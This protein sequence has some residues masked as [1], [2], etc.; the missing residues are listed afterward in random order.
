MTALGFDGSSWNDSVDRATSK[1]AEI[2][3]ILKTNLSLPHGTTMI[4]SRK[5]FGSQIRWRLTAPL[6]LSRPHSG[7]RG[8]ES[9]R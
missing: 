5:Y 4:R 7:Y 1:N 8:N 6:I 3:Q 9:K 2:G